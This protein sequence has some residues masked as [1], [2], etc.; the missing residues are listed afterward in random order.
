MYKKCVM[1]VRA[2]SSYYGVFNLIYGLVLFCQ[3]EIEEYLF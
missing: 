3:L 2:S 1:G